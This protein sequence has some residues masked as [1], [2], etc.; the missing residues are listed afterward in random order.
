MDDQFHPLIHFPHFLKDWVQQE[1]VV[2]QYTSR[3]PQ[4]SID[5]PPY[6]NSDNPKIGYGLESRVQGQSL[7]TAYEDSLGEQVAAVATEAEAERRV[8]SPSIAKGEHLFH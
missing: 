3:A 7:A 8:I 6:P 5:Q 1:L 2:D 4:Q